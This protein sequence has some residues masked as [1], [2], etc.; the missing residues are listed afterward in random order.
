MIKSIL[1]DLLVIYKLATMNFIR[2]FWNKMFAIDRMDC[3]F[4]LFNKQKNNLKNISMLLISVFYKN[5]FLRI[6]R[7]HR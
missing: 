6:R 4:V 3:C 7:R 2:L 1:F 5:P